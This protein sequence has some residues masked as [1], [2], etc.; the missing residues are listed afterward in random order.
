[1]SVTT[2]RRWGAV[3][4]RLSW[5][6]IVIAATFG[7]RNENVETQTAVFQT[8]SDKSLR[9]PTTVTDA[10]WFV[11]TTSEETT[12]A[13]YST[14]KEANRLSLL[15][16]LGGGVAVF[17]FERDG[18]LD[19][20]FVSGGKIGASDGQT[21]G[22]PPT[23]LVNDGTGN[24]SDESSRLGLQFPVSYSHGCAIGDVD[25]DGLSDAFLS[26]YGQSELLRNRDGEFIE[27]ATTAAGL[28]FTSWDTS[29]VIVDV[30][31]DGFP[32][33]FVTAYVSLD[34]RQR[35]DCPVPGK[36]ERDVCPPQHYS[37][38]RDRLY[39]NLG[40]G[41]F[42]DVTEDAGLPREGRGLGVLAADV[43]D[44]GWPDLYVAN[45]GDPN[46]LLLGAA[47]W[48]LRE[49]GISAGVAVNARGAAEGSMGLDYADIDGDGLGDLWVTN[50][51]L[52]D[53][54]LYR[55]LG[56]AQFEH[57][58]SQM[59]LTGSSRAN[60]GFGTGFYDFDGDNFP[61]LHVVNGHVSYFIRQSPFQ[62][63][64]FLYR[65]S[66]GKRFE[67]ATARGGA[68]FQQSHSARGTAVGD[69]DGNG[70]LD[71]V[72]SRLDAPIV[73][74]KNQH[75]PPNWISCRLIPLSGDSQ[76]VGATV[77]VHAFERD[78]VN[79]IRLG[80]SFASHSD[81]V[82]LF[83]IEPDREGVDITVRWAD[84]SETTYRSLNPKQ[85]HVLQQGN[86]APRDGR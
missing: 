72:V 18:D 70:T 19:I 15:E 57:F 75:T 64:P 7:C 41:T 51:E 53:N 45:D 47:E 81:N 78:V 46:H 28:T 33:I 26:C 63:P 9:L 85:L 48:P 1:M 50:F 13:R 8:D 80:T 37:A 42:R 29:A 66:N 67:N 49:V 34:T 76:G 5:S 11:A 31:G 36:R 25:R 27:S 56:N 52:E 79:H 20:L 62:Q 30:T 44:D 84:H 2:F 4:R 6:L 83:A 77:K 3:R 10:D 12:R 60:V 43:N 22:L 35:E 17:D 23:L 61:D 55:N 21:E 69:L 38:L 32:E 82:P 24:F 68:F 40:D 59:G 86:G 58:T 16:T 65:N 39:L 71:L 14:G 54:S 73:I 74:L